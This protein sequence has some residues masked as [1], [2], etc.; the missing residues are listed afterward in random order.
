MLLLLLFYRSRSGD[1]LVTNGCPP[2]RYDHLLEIGNGNIKINQIQMEILILTRYIWKYITLITGQPSNASCGTLKRWI[3]NDLK[4][5][6]A[7]FLKARTLWRAYY[8]ITKDMV[9]EHGIKQER[10]V[11]RFE[12]FYQIL[13]IVCKIFFASRCQQSKASVEHWYTLPAP[14]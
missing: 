8:H 3:K 11:E 5:G 13:K 9:L 1:Y 2:L 4:S 12:G 14:C 6:K 7:K 10:E